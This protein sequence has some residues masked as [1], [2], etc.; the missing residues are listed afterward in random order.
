MDLKS[1]ISDR[2]RLDALAADTGLSRAYL[3][4]V[5]NR[6][7]GRKPSP[8]AA[9]RIEEATNYRVMRWESLP[10]TYDEP[11]GKAA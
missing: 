10:E 4:Q 7:G 1:Y 6:Y 8:A 9:K 5:A 11:K 3:R 2:G